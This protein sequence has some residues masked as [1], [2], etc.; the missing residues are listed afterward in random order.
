M[1]AQRNRDLA[2]DVCLVVVDLIGGLGG[3][4]CL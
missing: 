2:L 4:I 1:I 3:L